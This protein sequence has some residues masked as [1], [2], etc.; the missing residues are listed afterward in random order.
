ML[1][2][3]EFKQIKD[4]LDS[5]SRPL[6]FF[7]DDPDG[8]CSFLLFYRY[9]REGKGIIVKSHPRVDNKF[10]KKI[11]EYGPDKIFILDIAI[12]E[13]DFID[14]VNVPVVWIDHHEPIEL[15]NVKYFNPRKNLKSSNIPTSLMCYNVV[16]QD[17]WIA[18]T[19][20]IGDWFIEKRI[21]NEFSKE[22]PDLL[23]EVYDNPGKI[24]YDTKLG[25]LIRAFSF[26][27]KG[28]THDAEKCFK[29]LTRVE[30]PYEILKH[31]SSQGKFIYKRY[32][33]IKKKYDEIM[34]LV[35]EK[36]VDD[37]FIIFTYEDDK[38]SFTGDISNELIYKYPKKIILI[39]RKKSG[40]MRCSLR[41]GKG[42][43]VSKMLERALVGIDG[44]GGGHE[45]A[46]GACV[47]IE[48]FDRFVENLR[49]EFEEEKKR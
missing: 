48:D 16:K 4:E 41:S 9:L 47:K 34:S 38:M 20:F 2:E 29:I 11:E 27:L 5:C 15:D 33:E 25:E 32:K 12:V 13:Q 45:Q 10:M 1:T 31:D 22:Y 46:C 26:C 44:F 49:R 3:K 28:S 23:K 19:G 30:S 37:P 7:H 40:E 39:A 14:K 42:I 35:K 36:I 8:L 17:L 43:M 24:L 6:I 18:V 21:L